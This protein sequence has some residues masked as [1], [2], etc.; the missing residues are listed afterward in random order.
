MSG[1]DTTWNLGKIMKA[2]G[3]VFHDS[4]EIGDVYTKICE[5]EEYPLK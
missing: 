1:S 5:S 3:Q 4:P 2:I